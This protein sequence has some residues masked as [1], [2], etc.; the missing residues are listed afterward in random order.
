MPNDKIAVQNRNGKGKSA[1]NT[2]DD[3]NIKSLQMASSHD[4]ILFFTSTGRVFG[5]KVWDLPNTDK[6]R[7]IRN[8]FESLTDNVVDMLAVSDQTFEEDNM[9]I[10]ITTKMGKVRRSTISAYKAAL[11]GRKQG[12][13]GFKVSDD[14]EVISI[15]ICK[16]NDHLILVSN[17][18]TV[19]RLIIDKENLRIMNKNAAG[20]RG[21]KL[22]DDE[23]VID[24][25]VIPVSDDQLIYTTKMENILAPDPNGTIKHFNVTYS[26]SG[27]QAIQVLDTSLIDKGRYLMTISENGVGKKTSLS[28]FSIKKRNAAKG[29]LAT[30]ESQKSGKLIKAIIVSD[31]DEVI[32]T[33][34]QKTIKIAVDNVNDYGR[35]AVGVQLM[36]VKGNDKVVSM[37]A[38]PA[39]T[40]NETD[41]TEDDNTVES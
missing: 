34:Q 7:H 3:D 22:K 41:D 5:M 20:M 10:I 28:E 38:V 14:D 9:Q 8:L 39:I 21:M 2:N 12:I 33:T 17:K 31:G 40:N 24:A 23:V 29:L 36:D 15:S 6:G 11:G 13:A 4:N 18:N 30:K 26:V 16:E 37:T 32:I 35:Y 19:N 1:I 25:I 27:Q